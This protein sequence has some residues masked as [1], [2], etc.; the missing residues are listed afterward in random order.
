MFEIRM[1]LAQFPAQVQQ[2]MAEEQQQ[3]SNV[4]SPNTPVIPT[5]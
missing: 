3:T 1:V 5:Q 2:R 4:A